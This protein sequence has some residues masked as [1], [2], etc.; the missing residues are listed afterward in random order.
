MRLCYGVLRTLGPLGGSP[1]H[2]R[3]GQLSN[4][5]VVFIVDPPAGQGSSKFK[6]VPLG[7]LSIVCYDGFSRRVP[8]A[9]PG[10]FVLRG[11]GGRVG[12]SLSLAKD[13]SSW[14]EEVSTGSC[15]IVL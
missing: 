9:G 2:R 4:I 3:L 13:G 11:G 12:P 7:K 5:R 1:D 15:G 8:G 14:M 6:L 10:K